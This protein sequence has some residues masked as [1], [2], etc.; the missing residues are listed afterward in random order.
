MEKTICREREK[1]EANKK[2]NTNN[3]HIQIK[4]N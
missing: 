3:K 4:N 1:E 2:Q